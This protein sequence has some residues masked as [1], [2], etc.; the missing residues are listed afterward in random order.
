MTPVMVCGDLDGAPRR[1]RIA[2]GLRK[3][4]ATTSGNQIID[5]FGGERSGTLRHTAVREA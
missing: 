5:L 3:S 4:S 1:S 2:P